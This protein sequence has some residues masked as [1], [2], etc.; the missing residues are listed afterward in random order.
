MSMLCDYVGGMETCKDPSENMTSSRRCYEGDD[1][2][3]LC[4]LAIE[5]D[6]L[7]TRIGR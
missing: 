1:D 4:H 3:V 7:Q 6:V 5:P 2:H